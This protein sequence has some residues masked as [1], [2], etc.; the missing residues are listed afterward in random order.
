M[1]NDLVS[2]VIPT[3]NR[4]DKLER[5][6]TS[7]VNQTY[8]KI[9][10]IITSDNDDETNKALKE[11]YEKLDSRIKFVVNKDEK[12]VGNWNNG[13]SYANGK[14]I[15][16]LYD[17]DWLNNDCIETCVGSIGNHRGVTFKCNNYLP[18][19]EITC[20]PELKNESLNR[21][22]AFNFLT[23]INIDGFFNA[24]ISPCAY[25]FKNKKIKFKCNFKNDHRIAMW[26]SGADIIY[27]IDNLFQ[28]NDEIENCLL[29][30]ESVLV[31]FES[32]EN[33]ITIA[34]LKEVV[35]LTKEGMMHSRKTY[36]K[37]IL[38]GFI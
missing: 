3:Y 37:K 9:E 5:A 19:G 16:I 32:H 7:A 22:E 28:D 2:I 33:S 31:N 34:N 17:D 27:I 8:D 21:A 4:F 6:V 18:N 26:G 14:F 23:S 29:I 24:C 1:Q 36:T 10:I 11:K 38:T 25:F 12:C 35:S 20:G 30:T 15:K 13:L